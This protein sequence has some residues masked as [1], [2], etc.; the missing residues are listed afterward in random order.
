MSF[1][2][3]IIL[4]LSFGWTLSL[5]TEMFRFVLC[6]GNGNDVDNGTCTYISITMKFLQAHCYGQRR[7]D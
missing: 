2:I 5:V 4:L 3:I 6:Y 7:E 1:S